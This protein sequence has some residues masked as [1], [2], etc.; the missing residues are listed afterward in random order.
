MAISVTKP[1]VGSSE[2]TWGTTL[3]TALDT[4]TN[5]VNGTSGT[6]EPDLTAGSWKIGGAAV[7]STAAE[8]N[9]MDGVTA[10]ATEINLL[11]GKTTLETFPVGGIILWSGTVA[12]IPTGWALCDGTNGTPNLTGKFVVHA[13]AD[14]SGTYNVGDTGGADSVTLTTSQIPSHTHTYIDQYTADQ[15]RNPGVDRDFDLQT[16]WNPYATQTRTSNA[17]GGG[18]SHENRPPY[19]ALAYI[20]KT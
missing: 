15:R 18:Q 8:L 5:A 3:N 14:S 2:N 7:T 9:I 11:A 10:T 16:T 4:I 1:V 12:A 17:T 19:Y 20:M 13:D 6:I